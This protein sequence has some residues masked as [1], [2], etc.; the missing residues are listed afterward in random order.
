M[1]KLLL[2]V[3]SHVNIFSCFFFLSF[4]ELFISRLIFSKISIRNTCTITVSNNLDP[5]Q[6]RHLVRPDLGPNC[7]ERLSAD[8]TR[9]QR[10]INAR[11]AEKMFPNANEIDLHERDSQCKAFYYNRH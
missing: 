7:L 8:N 9:R 1:L 4:A 2:C 6:A 10:V 3:L 5:D 11:M